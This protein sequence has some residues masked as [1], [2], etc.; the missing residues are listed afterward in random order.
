MR[1]GANWGLI[2]G[3]GSAY[4]YPRTARTSAPGPVRA[5][6][7]AARDGVAPDNSAVGEHAS[8]TPVNR[9]NRA[10]V[11]VREVPDAPR[12]GAERGLGE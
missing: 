7:G 8:A 1:K 3:I 6:A 5:Q 10:D 9:T 11:V 2:R 12:T 4:R